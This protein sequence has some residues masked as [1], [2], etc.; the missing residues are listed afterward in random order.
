MIEFEEKT[1]FRVDGPFL[2]SNSNAMHMF[3]VTI[4]CYASAVK[5][6]KRWG[7]L[8]QVFQFM[9]DAN[10]SALIFI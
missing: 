10:S 6:L 5:S 4:S 1:Y 2:E 3:L 9:I 8:Q 7:G